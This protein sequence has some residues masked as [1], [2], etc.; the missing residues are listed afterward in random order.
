[1]FVLDGGGR[2]GC[3]VCSVGITVEMSRNLEFSG[4][5]F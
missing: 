2:E 3:K 5:D 4:P 1:M